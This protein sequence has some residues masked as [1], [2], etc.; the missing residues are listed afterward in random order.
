MI[1]VQS[2]CSRVFKL[3]SAKL[4]PSSH[5]PIPPSIHLSTL[6]SIYLSI[7]PSIHPS[8]HSFI[9]PSIP[10]SIHLSILRLR[11][12]QKRDNIFSDPTHSTFLTKQF[13]DCFSSEFYFCLLQISFFFC[14]S[15]FCS[16]FTS[17]RCYFHYVLSRYI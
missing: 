11:S 17:L 14:L 15:S 2:I 1:L 13:S 4:R 5:P 6:T 16:Y 10:P 9:R 3:L 7:H 8:I 12:F